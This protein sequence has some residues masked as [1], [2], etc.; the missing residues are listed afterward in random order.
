MKTR[1]GLV[2]NSSSSSFC[3][4]GISVG[5]FRWEPSELFRFIKTFKQEFPEKF[6]EHVES[7]I[8]LWASQKE[9]EIYAYR[10]NMY[11]FF[12][13]DLTDKGYDDFLS[14]A[15]STDEE[16]SNNNREEIS[17]IIDSLLGKIAL[18]MYTWYDARE[19]WIGR[20]FSKIGDSETG[21]AFKQD[22][23]NKIN[24]LFGPDEKCATHSQAWSS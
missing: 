21:L 10:V 7:S 3:I 13:T 19:S 20:S 18:T 23:Q 16:D 11:N 17:E 6:N 2:S 8:E 15:G 22:I 5:E 14:A 1:H 12:K 4:Y 9:S 24:K